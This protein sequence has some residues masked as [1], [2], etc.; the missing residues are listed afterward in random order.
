MTSTGKIAAYHVGQVVGAASARLESKVTSPPSRY[1]EDTLLDAMLSAHRF[2]KTD[3]DRAILKETEGLGTSRTRVPTISNLIAR[4]LLVSQKK[5][6]RHELRS[7][8]LARA[9]IGALPPILT[10]VALTAKWEIAFGMV[11]SGKISWRQVVERNDQFVEYIV[12]HARQQQ[13]QIKVTMPAPTK[14]G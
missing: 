13:G 12:S 11:E 9:V 1:S 4:G 6:K 7:S 2:A 10:D 14:R 3:Q 5:G 8:D